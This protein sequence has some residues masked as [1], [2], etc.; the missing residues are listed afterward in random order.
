MA[1]IMAQTVNDWELI[2]CDSYSDDGSWEFFQKYQKD[3]RVRLYQVPREGLFAG[4]NE[5]LRR[6]TGRY[7][8]IATSDDTAYPDLLARLM[9]GLER[10]PPIGVAV[11]QFDFID[12]TGR[13]IAPT[14][15]VPGSFFGD[16]QARRHVR[17]GW[18]DFLVHTQLGTSW[19][20]ITSALFRADVVERAGLF[21]TDVGKGEAYADRFWA[22]KV[23]CLADT[24]SIPEKVA[25]WRVHPAQASR[26]EAFGWRAKNLRMTAET[27]RDCEAR[28]PPRW[29]MDPQWIEK[30]LFGMRQY[31]LETYRLDRHSMKTA[32]LCFMKGLGKA[33]LREPGYLIKRLTSGLSWNSP[34]MQNSHEFVKGLIN[35]WGVP[36]PPALDCASEN[37]NGVNI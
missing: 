18:V 8:Y 4:W 7:I 37:G 12:H 14:Q 16:W 25:T 15:G 29:I 21:R 6:V 19:T 13:I 30:L 23:A 3:P 28:I 31:Y 34:E 2:I 10:A 1:S 24:V 27:I 11:G 22:M 36:W 17:S 9:G 33:A 26:G 20:S 32:P 35:E 5:C